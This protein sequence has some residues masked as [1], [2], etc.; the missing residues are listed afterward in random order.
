MNL[1]SGD[2]AII[3]RHVYLGYGRDP[4]L[5][6]IDLTIPRGAFMPLV[7]PNGAGK[8]TLMRGILGLLKPIRGTITIHGGMVRLGYVSQRK[9]IDPLFPLTLKH[10]VMMGLYPQLGWWR[11]P[12]AQQKETVRRVLADLGLAEHTRKAFRE[13]SGGMKQKALIARAL[14]CGADILV[15]DEPTSELDAP[16]ER[17]IIRHLFRLSH[18]LG[19]TVLVAC[20]GIQLAVT[21]ADQVCL[22]DHGRAHIVDREAAGAFTSMDLH[23]GVA[24]AKEPRRAP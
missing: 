23:H 3:C 4:V 10:I 21:L 7:G 13:L 12:T 5:Y 9:E 14:V 6:D 17:D 24:E 22:V 2:A 20:H 11:R 19:K 18:E 1:K 8:T 15:L 16:S